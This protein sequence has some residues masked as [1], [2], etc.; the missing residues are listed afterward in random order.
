M[1]EWVMLFVF[2]QEI[3]IMTDLP[4]IRLKFQIQIKS[5]YIK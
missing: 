2:L 1:N 5:F 4:L 3:E